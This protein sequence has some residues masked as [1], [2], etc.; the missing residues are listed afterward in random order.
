MKS[1]STST[2][3]RGFSL[4]EVLIVC[5]IILIVAGIAIPNYLHAQQAAA[6][7]SAVSSLRIIHSSEGTYR[8]T[9]GQYGD[10]VALV[11]QGYFSDPSLRNGYKSRYAFDIALPAD[12]TTNYSATATPGATV[13]SW[14][15]YFIDG[16]GVIRYAVGTAATASSPEIQ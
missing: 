3:Q 12:P 1:N 14:H 2:R 9:F 13:G 5:A 8:S 7:A 10:F 15:N 6:A 16:S 4:I 11:G